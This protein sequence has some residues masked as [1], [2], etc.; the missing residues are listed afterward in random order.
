MENVYQVINRD[1]VTGELIIEYQ[2]TH[3]AK[4]TIPLT[5]TGEELRGLALHNYLM[6][7]V[8]ILSAPDG[9]V[10]EVDPTLVAAL[11]LDPTQLIKETGEVVYVDTAINKPFTTTTL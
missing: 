1:S 2:E 7:Q 8:A 9:P 4:I 5:E 10:S 3:E 11:G 6:D